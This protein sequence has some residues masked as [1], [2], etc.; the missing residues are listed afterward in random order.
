MRTILGLSKTSTS[1]GWVLVDGRDAAAEPLDFDAFD[2]IDGSTAA[3]AATARR[4]RDI[5]TASGFTVD[6]VH[7]TSSGNVSSLC[8]ALTECG[9]NDV[10]SVPLVEAT[11]SWG[12]DTGYANAMEKTAICV[13]GQD[14]AALSTIDTRSGAV[15]CVTTTVTNDLATFI[16]WLNFA[17][18][19]DG[20]RA[21]ALYL[22]GSRQQLDNLAGPL[23]KALHVPVVATGDAQI[24]LARGAASSTG[25]CTHFATVE[26]GGPAMRTRALTMVSAVAVVSV[27][28]LSSAASSI[29]LPQG[30]A[31]QP[32]V[33]ST[34]ES[35]QRPAVD[36]PVVP[37]VLPP[38]PPAAAVTPDFVVPEAVP[39]AAPEFVPP[40]EHLA[41]PLPVEHLPDAHGVAAPGPVAPVPAPPDPAVGAPDPL[42]GALP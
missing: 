27:F 34:A 42:F 4:V 2:I 14:S 7:V 8:D 16:S 15:Q 30:R 33:P 23:D 29:P 3:P 13:F 17:I 9:F 41:D 19:A 28:T 38:P 5:A 32:A 22:I 21:D 40:V 12:R 1:I 24:A 39:A 37:M 31:A 36:V 35:V 20:T 25:L 18:V 10:V 11:R 26:C 6:S